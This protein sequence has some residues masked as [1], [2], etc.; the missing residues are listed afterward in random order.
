MREIHT[1]QAS[2]FRTATKVRMPIWLA[3]LIATTKIQDLSR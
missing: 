2:K 1:A 3:L